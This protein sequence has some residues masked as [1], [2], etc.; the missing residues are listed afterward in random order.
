MEAKDLSF[1]GQTVNADH[2]TSKARKASQ[3]AK[4]L[5]KPETGQLYT[6]KVE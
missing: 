5:E 4:I 2:R 3:K 6:G 1:C